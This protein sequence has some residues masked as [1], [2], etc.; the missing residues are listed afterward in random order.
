MLHNLQENSAKPNKKDKPHVSS[1]VNWTKTSRRD[2]KTYLRGVVIGRD[3][4]GK[5]EDV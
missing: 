1:R 4:T 5:G 3:E 2:K